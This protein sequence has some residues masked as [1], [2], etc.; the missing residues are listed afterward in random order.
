MA[1]SGT[2]QSK[3]TV[4][5]TGTRKSGIYMWGDIDATW[6]DAIAT[7]GDSMIIPSNQDKSLVPTY[8]ELEDSSVFLLEDGSSLAMEGGSG[9]MVVTNQSKS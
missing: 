4:T 7:W 1:I 9:A 3:N 8:L 2:N 5:P 6:G